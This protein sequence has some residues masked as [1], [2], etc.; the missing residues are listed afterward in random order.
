M[1]KFDIVKPEIQ[2]II[3][4]RQVSKESLRQV[5][6][7]NLLELE[8]LRSHLQNLDFEIDQEGDLYSLLKLGDRKVFTGTS[9][10]KRKEITKKIFPLLVRISLNEYLEKKDTDKWD[11]LV[12]YREK[13]IRDFISGKISYQKLTSGSGL[14]I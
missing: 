13:E 8:R 2:E 3:Q 12:I 10:E 14:N 9:I 1:I 6:F 7:Y 5:F 11:Y 4:E